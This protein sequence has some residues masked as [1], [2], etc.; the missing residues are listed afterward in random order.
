VTTIESKA[1]TK[2]FTWNTK[3]T[4]I[5]N[6]TGRSFNWGAIINGTSGYNFITGTVYN[7]NGN[8]EILEN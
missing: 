6:K 2:D 5:I 7:N 1:L 3:L 8:V 4:K